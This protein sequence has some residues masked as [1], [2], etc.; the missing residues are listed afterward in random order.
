MQRPRS[1]E[2]VKIDP[3]IV[4]VEELVLGNVFKSVLV[5]VRRLGRLSQDEAAV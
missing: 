2:A 5:L 4:G 3:K 1:L